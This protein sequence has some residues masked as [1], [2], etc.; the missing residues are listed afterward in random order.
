MKVLSVGDIHGRDNWK[1]INPD[2]YDKVVFLGDYVDHYTKTPKEILN[3]FKDVLMFA[4]KYP[5]KVVL[6]IGNHDAQYFMLYT[7]YRKATMCTGFKSEYAV[8]LNSLFN[9]NSDMFKYMYQIDNYLWSHAGLSNKS[10]NLFYKDKIELLNGNL[11]DKFNH[12]WNVKNSS[13]FHVGVK[14]GGSYEAGSPLWADRS[15]TI[16]DCL[17]G[18][19]QIVGHTPVKQIDIRE[20]NLSNCSIAYVD[21]ADTND[22]Y[23]IDT[24]NPSDFGTFND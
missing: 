5:D 16:M 12:L 15:E 1:I 10:F 3:N 6:L 13:I 4:K 20:Y 23:V 17:D 11:A 21:V 18:Y 7:S 8:A 19:H 22:F 2:E 24:E 14:R 9:D